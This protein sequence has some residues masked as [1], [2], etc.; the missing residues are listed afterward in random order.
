V[1]DAG[2]R[3][4]GQNAMVPVRIAHEG[5]AILGLL[6]LDTATDP[7]YER[8]GIFTSLA[9]QLYA[10]ESSE[11]PLVFGFP[12]PISAPILY[13]RLDWVELRPYPLFVRPLGSVGGPVRA[14]RAELAPLAALVD[15][16]APAAGLIER[17]IARREEARGAA[18]RSLDRFGPWADE[19]WQS[20]APALGTAVIR[21]AAYLN[22]RFCDAPAAPTYRRL[23]LHRH[24]EPVGLVV[25]AVVPWRGGA[26]AYLMELMV[27]AEDTS[28]ARLLL[29]HAIVDAL[30]GGA[31]A[32]NAVVTR[33][34][35][36]RGTLLRAGFLPVPPRFA[37]PRS[38][39]VRHNG[40][41]V[42]PDRIFH[43]DDWYLSC[44]DFDVV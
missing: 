36:H 5:K 17:A 33:R 18:V 32:L 1:A 20:L 2:D 37:A 39:G 11:A 7:D 6:S 23:A 19:L 16:I 24:G 22:W 34:H 25:T 3:L 38:F 28:G 29:A 9:R 43:M 8:Q 26:M 27:P 12:N 13:K 40:P 15:R 42:V 30:R 41:G 44:A 4:A 21:D 31:L 35:P 14:W 10:E